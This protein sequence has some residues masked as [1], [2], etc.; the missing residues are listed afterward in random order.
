MHRSKLRKSFGRVAVCHQT[1]IATKE[2]N[3]VDLP[4]NIPNLML[5]YLNELNGDRLET[6]LDNLTVQFV[7][8]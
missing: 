7:Q 3:A 8:I 6:E 5:A 1:I 4:D 2:G